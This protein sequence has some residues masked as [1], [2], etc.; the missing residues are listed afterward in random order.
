MTNYSV[1]SLQDL[2]KLVLQMWEQKSERTVWLLEGQVGSGK[3]ETVKALART[4]HLAQVASPSFAIHHRY[5]GPED[6]PIDHLD[7]YRLENEEDLES[8]GFWDLFSEDRGLIIIEWADQLNPAY[9]P[10]GWKFLRWTYRVEKD[11]SR[12]IGIQKL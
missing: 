7:L 4:L 2:E 5:K 9:L 1:S 6:F 10:K 12:Q 3:T 8:T 11:Q